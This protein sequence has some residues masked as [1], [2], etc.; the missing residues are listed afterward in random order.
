MSTR[1][2]LTNISIVMFSIIGTFFL[3]EVLFRT[4]LFSDTNLLDSLRVPEYYSDHIKNEEDAFYNDNYWKLNYLFRKPI[5]FESPHPLLGWTGKFYWKS[6]DHFEQDSVKNK[7]PIL[8]YGDS[9]AMCID[10]VKCFEDYLNHDKAF[11]KNHFLL[12]YGVGGYGVD[13]IYLLLNETVDRFN[14]PF[15]IF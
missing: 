6:L 15:I 5:N 4:I 11:I 3:S 1:K 8:L 9:F 10:S 13:Q 12:N 14:K 7:R 2:R